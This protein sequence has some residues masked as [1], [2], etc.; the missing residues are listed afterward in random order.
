MGFGALALA[1]AARG[2]HRTA[3]LAPH[4]PSPSVQ[5]GGHVHLL[6]VLQVG[7]E[8]KAEPALHAVGAVCGHRGLSG[9][10][11]QAQRPAHTLPKSF[12]Y[13]LL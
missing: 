10:S 13:A 11:G 12:P 1:R 6:Q 4:G 7:V 8:D 5:G 2:A 9:G 3:H